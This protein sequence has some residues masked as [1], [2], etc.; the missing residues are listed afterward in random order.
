MKNGI[1]HL[2]L[3]LVFLFLIACKNHS[4][5]PGYTK[6][7]DNFYYKLI[8]IGDDGKKCEYNDF[9]TANI[10]YKTITDSVIFKGRRKF[11]ISKPDFDGSVDECM[12]LMGKDDSAGFIISAANF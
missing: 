10:V 7:T 2:I 9:I 1:C 5:F 6:H 12:T 3:F 4:D 8:K 11:Q